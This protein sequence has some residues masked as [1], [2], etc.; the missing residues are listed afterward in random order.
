[1]CV[2]MN[3]KEPPSCGPGQ[4]GLTCFEEL[5]VCSQKHERERVKGERKLSLARAR[6]SK[7]LQ[8]EEGF[9]TINK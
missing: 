5:C 6:A 4:M 2:Y 1:V 7:K 3:A 9:M 8:E